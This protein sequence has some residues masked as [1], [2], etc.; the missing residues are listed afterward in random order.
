MDS[1]ENAIPG[2]VLSRQN[3]E[4]GPAWT[5]PGGSHHRK[6][7]LEKKNDC[8]TIPMASQAQETGLAQSRRFCSHITP[9]VSAMQTDS[10]LLA[11]YFEVPLNRAR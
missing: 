2:R 3:N 1:T 5:A 4:S 8:P 6:S 10:R 7:T 9:S 11:S